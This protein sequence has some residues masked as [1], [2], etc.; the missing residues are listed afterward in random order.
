MKGTKEVESHKVKE[1]R[2]QEMS[3]QQMRDVN[4]IL[5][6][7]EQTDD[8]YSNLTRES[9]TLSEGEGRVGKPWQNPL[10]AQEWG[11]AQ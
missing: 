5:E 10:Q 3:C 7:R 11:P 9:W 1:Y 2:R 4:K 6:A 8:W